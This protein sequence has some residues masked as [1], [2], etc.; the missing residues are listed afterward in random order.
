VPV[1][2]QP[3][4]M[5]VSEN[6]LDRPVLY[7]TWL[8]TIGRVKPGVS[9]AQASGQLNALA[10]DADWRPP[11]KFTGERV[12]VKL[13]LTSA[14]TGLSDLRHQFS[15]P[16]FILSGVVGIVLLIAC[17]NTGNLV[18]A[19]SAARRP[20]FALRLAL[21]AGRSRLIRQVLIEA[22]VLAGLAGACGVALAY[23]ATQ[24][25]VA[26]ASAGRSAIVLDVTPDVRVLVFMA[27]CSAVCRPSGRRVST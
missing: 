6:L 20:E 13:V 16:L 17:A 27:C 10:Q 11:D 19:R 1:M 9:L 15:L 5:P 14:A 4:V 2:M 26:Y 3:I 18:L 12:E 25:L 24:A 21:G 8:R 22:V 23:W 7:S